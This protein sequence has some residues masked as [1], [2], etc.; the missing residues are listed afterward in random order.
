MSPASS[1]TVA[2]S[3]DNRI[4][5]SSIV[6]C[7]DQARRLLADPRVLILDTETTGLGDDD[8]IVEIA[9]INTQGATLLDTLV[10]PTIPIGAEAAYVHGLQD[11]DLADAPTFAD[12]W[13]QIAEILTGKTILTY[14]MRFDSAMLT[15][16]AR[17]HA[18]NLNWLSPDLD[19][20]LGCLMEMS[21]KH[22]IRRRWLSLFNCA[23]FLGVQV[24]EPAHRALGD[25][26]T[27]LAIL[28][29]I[30]KESAISG[31]QRR[32]PDNDDDDF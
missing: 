19:V 13:P 18:I 11:A 31:E 3:G 25:A 12:L 27:A 20:K 8:Q 17:A 26:R 6:S 5:A 24:Q 21:T 16:S 22:L 1:T 29:A 23:A 14:N 32:P 28:I 4:Y 7:R 30:A 10:R 9:I 15:Q 2:P